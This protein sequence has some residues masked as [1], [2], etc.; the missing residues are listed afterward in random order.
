MFCHVWQCCK[1]SA[2]VC[3]VIIACIFVFGL[4]SCFEALV[5]NKQPS[6][7]VYYVR[8]QKCLDKL[9]SRASSLSLLSIIVVSL[10]ILF[11]SVLSVVSCQ[12]FL[13]TWEC[14]PC[15][16]QQDEGKQ[17]CDIRHLARSNLS[18]QISSQQIITVIPFIQVTEYTCFSRFLK[19]MVCHHRYV[20][21]V[22]KN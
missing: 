10:W 21:S 16:I 14:A 22:L 9:V 19:G 5:N 17:T 15:W 7:W 6:H 11:Y 4:L 12:V 18:D 8:Q 20:N 3:Y 13:H 1:M 2:Q